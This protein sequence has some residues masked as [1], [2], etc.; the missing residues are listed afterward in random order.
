M[1]ALVLEPYGD[2]IDGL[3]HCMSSDV[4]PRLD[5]AMTLDRLSEIVRTDFVWA[6]AIDFEHRMPG[7]LLVRLKTSRNRG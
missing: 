5:P 6:L 3:A 1:V 4:G 7:A 2:L